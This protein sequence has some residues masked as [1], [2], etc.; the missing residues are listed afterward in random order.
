MDNNHLSSPYGSSSLLPSN[1]QYLIE[2]DEHFMTPSPVSS[3]FTTKFTQQSVIH[4]HV[5]HSSPTNQHVRS[6]PSQAN[7]IS[8]SP[9]QGIENNYTNHTPYNNHHP[10]L[11]RPDSYSSSPSI[12]PHHHHHH[13]DVE[14][15]HN[16][17]M[18][19]INNQANSYHSIYN[20]ST[21]SYQPNQYGQLME[22]LGVLKADN[23]NLRKEIKLK[24]SK[25]AA[26]VN[27]IKTFW[28]PELKKE[29]M[30]KREEVEKSELLKD[31]FKMIMEESQ[32]RLILYFLRCIFTYF[33][34][35]YLYLTLA[36]IIT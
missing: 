33:I 14:Q 35:F 7:S 21:P 27:S 15:L 10:S 4:N 1:Q 31:R 12:S 19:T 25:L 2:Q 28:S 18:D 17:N 3:S 26:T 23:E 30:I 11:P 20:S 5:N 13:P 22:Q 8:T 24:D 9:V 16:H 29:S 32:V 36:L 34:T 6:Y